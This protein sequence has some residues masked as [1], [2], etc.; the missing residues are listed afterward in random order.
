MGYDWKCCWKIRNNHRYI[1]PVGVSEA[2]LE[3]FHPFVGSIEVLNFSCR[4]D[5]DWKVSGMHV[6]LEGSMMNGHHLYHGAHH[7]QHMLED[8]SLHD[9]SQCLM[10]QVKVGR[11]SL[12]SSTTTPRS[13]LFMCHF[14]RRLMRLQMPAETTP[15]RNPKSRTTT[16]K[17]V[18]E[19]RI[20]GLASP[21]GATTTTR[22]RNRP[23][24]TRLTGGGPRGRSTRSWPN[25]P[26]S[27][28]RP[29]PR[30]SSAQPF[31]HTG[32][33]TRRCLWHLKWLHLVT[34]QTAL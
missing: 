18:V 34:L 15:R 33:R 31:P 19:A 3:N 1:D 22:K 7:S 13:W 23:R 20:P 16:M 29:G 8:Q 30:L 2:Q 12:Q 24:Y 5:L 14:R 26:A 9:E 10:G 25:T 21:E 6:E 32:G 27:W 17:T 28:S 4:P 11:L